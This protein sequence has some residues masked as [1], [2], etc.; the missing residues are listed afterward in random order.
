M[1]L[2]LS[3]AFG[4]RLEHITDDGHHILIEICEQAGRRFAIRDEM[5]NLTKVNRKK[6]TKT[7]AAYSVLPCPAPLADY[8]RTYMAA[9]HH[10][11]DGTEVD[12]TGRLVHSTRKDD[13][14]G[15]AAFREAFTK[16]THTTGLCYETLGFHVTP[17]FLRKSYSAEL[18]WISAAPEALRSRMLGHNVRGHDGG[19]ELTAR[20][21]TP[22]SPDMAPRIAAVEAFAQHMQAQ[23]TTLF[24]A[25]RRKPLTPRQTRNATQDAH[26]DAVFAA[27]EPTPTHEALFTV[28]EAAEILRLSP[29][30]I[31]RRIRRAELRTVREPGPT[32]IPTEMILASDLDQL[33]EASGPHWGIPQAAAEVGITRMTLWRKIR[34][35]EVP[36]FQDPVSKRWKLGDHAIEILRGMQNELQRLYEVA[37]PTNEVCTRLGLQLPTVAKLINSGQLQRHPGTDRTGYTFVTKESLEALIARRNAGQRRAKLSNDR[38]GWIPIDEAVKITGLPKRELHKLVHAWQ[39]L[40]RDFNGKCHLRAATPPG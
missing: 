23:N 36:A 2:R 12:R 7:E 35:G 5:G 19:A 28:A 24:V 31:R 18:R 33:Q 26:A 8:V 16:A 37:L 4:I 14:G 15:T 38:T 40:R 13:A 1:G 34:A 10:Q 11:P 29:M 9:Y 6:I 17:H 25:T 22:D 27:A 30:T 3:E 21:Y 32:G 20:V 39:L